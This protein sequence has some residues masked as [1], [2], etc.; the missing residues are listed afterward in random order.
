MSVSTPGGDGVQDADTGA[1]ELAPE[2][3]RERDHPRLGGR[4]GARGGEIGVAAD[5]GVVDHRAAPGREHLRQHAVGEVG[6]RDEVDLEHRVD[7]LHLL[8]LEQ[9]AGHLSR[10]VDEQ[11]DR[12]QLVAEGVHAGVER[13]PAREVEPDRADLGRTVDGLEGVRVAYAREHE[14]QRANGE[15][16]ADSAADAAVCAC[17]EGGA[18]GEVHL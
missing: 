4:V 1:P 12:G 18:A 8:L 15:R 9:P 10:V 11:V 5:R 14:P 3:L 13:L 16:F 17:D 2:R 7:G 6:D